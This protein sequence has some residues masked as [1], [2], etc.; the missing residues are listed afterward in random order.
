MGNRLRPGAARKTSCS[1]KRSAIRKR[2]NEALAAR[3][4]HALPPRPRGRAHA[5]DLPGARGREAR[6]DRRA[7]V[8][9]ARRHAREEAEGRRLVDIR[10]RVA[11]VESALPGRGNAAGNAARAAPPFLPLVGRFARH[12]G[13]ARTRAGTRARRPMP[14]RRAAFARAARARR[15]ASPLAA[16]NGPR[17]VS[18]ALGQGRCRRARDP[19]AD[20]RRAARPSAIRGAA[21]FGAGGRR[22][23][24][25]ERRVR[26]VGRLSRAHAGRARFRTAL[27]IPIWRRWPRRS[28]RGGRARAVRSRCD[29]RRRRRSSR[30]SRRSPRRAG[31][32]RSSR[33]PRACLRAAA[34]C[35]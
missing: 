9:V 15:A 2:S 30:R 23:G 7:I 29:G 19:R 31:N 13:A 33:C 17:R 32:R 22:A 20:V 34:A 5:R 27:P 26:R 14:R 12:A 1:R 3:S 35:W 24:L 8:R 6:A 4:V 25:R 10:L 21:R 11:S 28:S 18:P 16:R